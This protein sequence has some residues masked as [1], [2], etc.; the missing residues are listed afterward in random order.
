[1]PV[2]NDERYAASC[3]GK[4]VRNPT[5]FVLQSLRL[6]FRVTVFL[7]VALHSPIL[8][9]I[10]HG[11]TGYNAAKTG[12][13]KKKKKKIQIGGLRKGPKVQVGYEE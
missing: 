9:P 3:T 5:H 13:K 2:E 12:Q 4:H 1:M 10:P 7:V 8:F 6:Y 11:A